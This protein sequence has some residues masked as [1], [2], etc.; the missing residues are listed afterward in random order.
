[1]KCIQYRGGYKYQLKETYE[2][3]IKIQ[4]AEAIHTEFIKLATDGALTIEKN[5]AW[6][7]P[8]GPTIDTLNFMRGSL[9]HDALYQ[10][11]REGKLSKDPHREIAD[12]ILREM[13]R[14]D[15]MSAIR[16]WWVY[17]AVRWFGDPAVDPAKSKPIVYAPKGCPGIEEANP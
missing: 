12:K 7:G 11:I 1:M 2:V 9:V 8:S 4:Q 13:C 10:L 3:K 17:R 5:Y 6:D 14:Q 15:D 16:A